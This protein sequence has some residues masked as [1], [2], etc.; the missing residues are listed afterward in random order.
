MTAISI[1]FLFLAILAQKMLLQLRPPQRAGR[2]APPLL[3]PLR[4]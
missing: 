4:F 3:P 2:P 1:Q